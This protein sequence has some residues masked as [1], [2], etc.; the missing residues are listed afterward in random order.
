[1]ERKPNRKRK[2]PFQAR[3]LAREVLSA[4]HKTL[5]SAGKAA[6]YSGSAANRALAN[7]QGTI[8]DI[9]DQAGISDAYLVQNCLRP[10][11][12]AT[13]VKLGHYKGKFKDSVEVADNDARLRA[14]DIALRIKRK[15]APLARS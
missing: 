4:K 9:M 12:H 2:I 14:L 7:L 6:G 3:A 5:A 13:Q 11:L 1:M 10:L 15:Y 8:S